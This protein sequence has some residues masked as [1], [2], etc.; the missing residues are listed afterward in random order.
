[1]GPLVDCPECGQRVDL[2]RLATRRWDKPWYKAPGYNF[3]SLPAVWALVGTLGMVLFS[4]VASEALRPAPFVFWYPLVVVSFT[5]MI[6]LIAWSALLWL[7]YRRFGRDA[8]AVWYALLGHVAL[9]GYLAGV[10]MLAGG[11]ITALLGMSRSTATASGVFIGCAVFVGGIALFVTARFA[12]RASA[13]F[14]I[15]KWLYQD[16]G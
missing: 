2:V 15:R 12:E 3:L 1:M 5:G 11:L 7:A 4:L 14:C 6:V 9:G 16:A 10:V 8:R 13:K